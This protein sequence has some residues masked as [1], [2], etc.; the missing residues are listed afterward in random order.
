VLLTPLELFKNSALGQT[1]RTHRL[2]I[3]YFLME[4]VNSFPTFK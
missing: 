2:S 3:L 1:M 4:I